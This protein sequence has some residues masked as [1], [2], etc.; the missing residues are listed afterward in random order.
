MVKIN[1]QKT[2]FDVLYSKLKQ[3]FQDNE[4]IGFRNPQNWHFP[5]GMVFHGFGQKLEIFLTFHFM[6]N[7]PKKSIW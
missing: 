6:Q 2:T 7:T 4:N 5:K 3:A 1:R